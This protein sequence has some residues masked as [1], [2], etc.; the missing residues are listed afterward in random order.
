MKT[1]IQIQQAGRKCYYNE[2]FLQI[3]KISLIIF[4]GKE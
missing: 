1:G 4:C 3:M 2:H